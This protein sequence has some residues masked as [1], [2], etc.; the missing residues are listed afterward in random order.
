MAA[1]ST[2][3]PDEVRREIAS[4]RAQLADAV[5]ALRSGIGDVT[6]VSEK[7]RE[8]LPV[9]AA[10]ALG[11][12]FVLAGGIGATMRYIARRGREGKERARVGRFR[13]LERD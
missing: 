6:N 8:K 10:G 7:V 12:G 1:D 4:E 11:V 5:D 3:T 13:I 2:R 9:A